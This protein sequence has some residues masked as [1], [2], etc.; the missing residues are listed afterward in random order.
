MISGGDATRG[1]DNGETRRQPRGVAAR[2]RGAMRCE[3][4]GG[5]R[6]VAREAA[7]F[8]CLATRPQTRGG[9]VVGKA[10]LR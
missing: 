2:P 10:P 1:N 6:R 5:P 9:E 8:R 7:R 4:A 3:V